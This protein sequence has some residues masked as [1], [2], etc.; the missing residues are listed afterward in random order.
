MA[1]PVVPFPHAKRAK[2]VLVVEDQAPVRAF[3]RDLL[4]SEAC[5]EVLEAGTIA[6]MREA[7]AHEDLD[8]V[9]T[10]MRLADGDA[11]EL[12]EELSEEGRTLPP[13][14]LMSGFLSAEKMT[15][16]LRLG[17]R[18][19]LAKPFDPK[20]LV[21]CA[22]EVLEDKPEAP[23]VAPCARARPEVPELFAMDRKMSLMFRILHELP[24][25][26][27]VSEVAQ[28]ALEL[29]LEISG[30]AR[31]WIALADRARG[32]F[33]K[34]A[35][36]G[37]E[38][39]APEARFEETLLEKLLTGEEEALTLT[40]L[41][42]PPWPGAKAAH[43]LALPVTMQGRPTGVLVLQGMHEQR[44][45]DADALQMLSLLLQ[46]LDTLLDNRA[47]HAALAENMRETLVAL[48]R[49][50]EARDRYTRD[51]SQRVGRMSAQ[52]AREMG[53]DAETVALVE[54][55]GLLHDIGKVGIPDA[56]LLKPGKYTPQEFAIMKAHPA[57]GDAILRHMDA[58]V[59]ERLMVRHHHERYDGRG[60]PDGLAGDEIPLTAR[61][62][63]V[64]D[65]IDA[66]TTHRVYRRAQ[67]I[68]FALE[69][70]KRNA[71]TQFDPDVV[72]AATALIERGE[73]RSQCANPAEAGPRI[74]PFSAETLGVKG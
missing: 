11:L 25:R 41:D 27:R 30:D 20:A 13:T 49:I 23:N 19:V 3:V 47:V 55:G 35:G 71:G 36:I 9:V 16:A 72:K 24:R 74:L 18:R 63:C 34:I 42:P 26:G 51:H 53:L 59:R 44:R 60:Y 1:E 10:D 32:R 17:V 61:I 6:E 65:A 15:Q 54:L 22:E 28:A 64:A 8:L 62:V 70:L 68:S 66:M 58:L 69:E 40:P 73:I 39:I 12:L 31:G 57:I 46:S 33:V 21:S 2:R 43:G 50:L 4:Q 7:L 38:E 45:G 5:A 37:T 67:P 14:I 48:V 52:I 56:V 29:A